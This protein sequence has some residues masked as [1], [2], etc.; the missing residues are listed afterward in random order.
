VPV[1]VYSSDPN[2][3]RRIWAPFALWGLGLVLFGLV[4]MAWPAL[5]ARVFVTAFGILS[6][7]AGVT[8]LASAL[9]ARRRLEGLAYLPVIAGVIALAIGL[10]TLAAPEFVAQAFA[11]V[12]G[13]AAFAWGLSDIAIGWT[14]R[15]YFPTWRL[16]VFRGAMTVVAGVFLMFWPLEAQV[17]VA[18]L[19][20]AWAIAIGSLTLVLGLSART[21]TGHSGTRPPV[22]SQRP[23]D[24]A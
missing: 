15:R 19:V 5:T 8:Q 20:G 1:V 7:V 10:V 17:A 9:I 2:T 14:G 21:A 3:Y 4:I 6:L 11:F 13:A 22:R 12:I 23:E 18:W 24:A 16:H